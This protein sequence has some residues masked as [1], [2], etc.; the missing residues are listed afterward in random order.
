VTAARR[1][2]ALAGAL[3]I[4]SCVFPVDRTR[5]VEFVNQTSQ[6]LVLY[7]HGRQYPTAR[8][9]LPA[10]DRYRNVWLDPEIDHGDEK[11]K[12]RVEATNLA[13]VLVFCHDYTMN[14]FTQLKWVLAITE[15]NDCPSE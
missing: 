10:G 4:A 6:H 8:H 9:D 3:A 1:A 13:G 2:L 5:P 14:E 7:D 12:F 15:R 11:A